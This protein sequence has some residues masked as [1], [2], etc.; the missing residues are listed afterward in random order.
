MN[1]AINEYRETP[2]V[3]SLRRSCKLDQ[4]VLVAIC[5]HTASTGIFGMTPQDLWGRLTDVIDEAKLSNVNLLRPPMNVLL[6]RLE[7]LHKRGVLKV[8]SDK[9][10]TLWSSSS[11][12]LSASSQYISRSTIFTCRLQIADIKTAFKELP[13][14]KL[15]P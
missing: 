15:L 4:A 1:K 10:P 6:E 8:Q 3:A 9:H 5:K 12:L 2:F 7:S 11:S 13:F 14:F